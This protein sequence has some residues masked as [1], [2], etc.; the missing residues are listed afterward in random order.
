MVATPVG[1]VPLVPLVPDEPLEPDVP[2]VPEE[3]E[4]P[5]VP[6]L[7]EEPDVPDEPL[8]PDVP[9]EPELPLVPDE[10]LVPEEPEF[11][12]GVFGTNGNCLQT[13]AGVLDG[14]SL[15]EFI[16]ITYNFVCSG[17]PYNSDDPTQTSEA[18]RVGMVNTINSIVPGCIDLN[19]LNDILLAIRD[20]NS[21][22]CVFGYNNKTYR[23][24]RV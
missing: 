16:Q 3:P 23:Q 10:P 11:G 6:L 12:N 18:C 20:F 24:M 21:N 19:D 1:L 2:D 8:K 15:I 5:L 14:S 9:E 7:P 22:P 13:A 17:I 4:L